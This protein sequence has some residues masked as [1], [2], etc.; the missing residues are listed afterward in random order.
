MKYLKI[1]IKEYLYKK[2]K[3]NPILIFG[4]FSSFCV[5]S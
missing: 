3:Q 2:T 1:K 4:G 5:I